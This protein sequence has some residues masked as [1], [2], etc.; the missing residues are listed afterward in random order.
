MVSYPA[1]ASPEDPQ[2]KAREATQRQDTWRQW[3]QNDGWKQFEGA[4]R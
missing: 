2:K 1:N 3:W 4:A